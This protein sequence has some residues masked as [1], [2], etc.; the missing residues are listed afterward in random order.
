MA[1][2]PYIPSFDLFFFFFFQVLGLTCYDLPFRLF[3]RVA[4]SPVDI[5][6]SRDGTDLYMI[7]DDLYV[8]SA[9]PM[10]GFEQGTIGLNSLQR[11]WAQLSLGKPVI[12]KPFNIFADGA[13]DKYLA[14]LDIEIAFIG[15]HR[16]ST[17]FSQ[18][19]LKDSLIMVSTTIF[20]ILCI[21]LA[22]H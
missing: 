10:P 22:R 19:E 3:D 7:V 4:V 9:R 2:H 16:T 12:V 17:A 6:P 8:F 13:G 20:P 14:S 21:S 18:E 15:S 1:L 5:P 11:M